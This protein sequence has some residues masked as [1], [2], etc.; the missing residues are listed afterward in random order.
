MEKK[1]TPTIKQQ[2]KRLGIV[3]R[4]LYGC[5]YLSAMLPMGIYVI[6]NDSQ[7]FQEYNGVKYGFA[8][9]LAMMLVAVT[10]IG[11]SGEKIKGSLLAFTLKIGVALAI[12]ILI[13]E[14][15]FELENLLKCLFFGLLGSLGFETGSKIFDRMYKEKKESIKLAKQQNDIAQAREELNNK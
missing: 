3:K 15:I 6:I 8:L 10:I 13:R 2:A 7:Y 1:K 9:Y 14:I 12:V 11:V 5:E 4:A